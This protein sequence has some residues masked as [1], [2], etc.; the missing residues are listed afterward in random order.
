[1]K[2]K[3]YYVDGTTEEV[4]SDTW[5]PES[6]FVYFFWYRDLDR[7]KDYEWKKMEVYPMNNIKKIVWKEE[8][9]K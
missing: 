7:P 1:M 2:C 5:Q 6:G 3:I 8:E 9:K 4:I